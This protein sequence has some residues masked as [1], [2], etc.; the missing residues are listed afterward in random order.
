MFS[1]LPN[2]SIA[3]RLVLLFTVASGLLVTCSLGTFYWLLIR[4]TFEEDNAAMA[5]KVAALVGD[6]KEFG[7]AKALQSELESNRPGQRSPYWVRLIDP[8]GQIIAER[9]GMAGKLPPRAFPLPQSPVGIAAYPMNYRVGSDLYSLVSAVVDI[10]GDRYLLQLA[11]DRSSDDNF[12]RQA[13]LLFLVTVGIS[14]M[15]S[16]VIARSATKRGLRPLAEISQSVKRIQPTRLDQRVASTGWPNELQ[17][18]AESF[19]EMLTRLEDSFTRLSQFSADLAHELRTPISNILGEAQV[20][21]TR[22]RTADEYR[23]VIESTVAECERLSRIT[24]SLLFL[25]RADSAREQIKCTWFNGRA[26]VEKIAN[27]YTTLAE[28]R[29]IRIECDGEA[30]IHADSLLFTR[31]VSNLVDNALRFS[32]DG[33]AVRVSI[34]TTDDGTEISVRDNGGG[35]AAKHLGRVFDRFYR[36]DPSR[37]SGGTGLGLALVKSIAELHGGSV[38]IESEINRGTNITLRFPSSV[39]SAIDSS[40]LREPGHAS[41]FN[42][43]P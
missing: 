34:S 6:V 15:A 19:D 21:L 8:R 22:N 36:A 38:T 17:P 3:S 18:L 28:D 27:F 31:A 33:S 35:I 11:Q 29:H 42:G 13:S 12:N 14:I 25:A 16:A 10:N 24:D 32:P 7:P 26:A 39:L 23:Q 1:N 30:N 4:H 9:S 2:G 37:S 43:S 5:D 20:A 40:A 41:E